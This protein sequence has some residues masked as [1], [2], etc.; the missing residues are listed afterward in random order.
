MY[1]SLSA[2]LET[3][4]ATT[5]ASDASPA[6]IVLARLQA[7]DAR[8]V[9]TEKDFDPET[10]ELRKASGTRTGAGADGAVLVLNET[11]ATAL[12]AWL[13]T[14]RDVSFRVSHVDTRK[15]SRKPPPPFI[16]SSLQQEASRKLG[17]SPAR[18]MA[19]AQGLYEKGHITYMRTDSYTL[20]SAAQQASR[21]MVS[22]L[23]GTEFL[24]SESST[25]KT[26]SAS[27]KNAQ[28]AHEAIRPAEVNGKFALPDALHLSGD[29]F[30]LYSLIL[31]RTLASVMAPSQAVTN[32]YT[33]TASAVV[34]VMNATKHSRGANKSNEAGGFEQATFK[35]SDTVTVF[36]GYLAAQ[37]MFVPG[38]GVKGTQPAAALL[39]VGQALRLSSRRSWEAAAGS[40]TSME[41]PVEEG[42]GA[43]ADA[44]T[45]ESTNEGESS[46]FVSGLKTARHHTRPP[47]RFTESSFI[48]EMESLGV[49][50][51]STYAAIFQVLKERGYIVVDRQTIIPTVRGMVV[52]AFLERHFPRF[53]DAR[54][55]AEMEQ[56]L[57]LIARNE[58]NPQDF[59]RRFYL[60]DNADQETPQK[61][62]LPTVQA[63]L[64]EGMVDQAT[65]RRL[66]VPFLADLGVL[67]LS[68][69]TVNFQAYVD[70]PVESVS[71]EGTPSSARGGAEGTGRSLSGR[72]WALPEALQSDMRQI[73]PEA[74]R[75]VM[76]TAPSAGQGVGMHPVSQL[77]MV[78]KVG[79]FGPYL[80]VGTSREDTTFCS[81]PAWME[82]GMLS[83]DDAVL[84]ASLPRD[85]GEHP[86][87][88]RTVQLI[89]KSG[90]LEVIVQGYSTHVE[91]PP[92]TCISDVTLD[93][94]LAALPDAT[95]ISS[96]VGD[97]L[98]GSSEGFPVYAAVGKYGPYVRR[99]N[100]AAS[101][102]DRDP[103]SVS[104]EE[105]LGLLRE[106]GRPFGSKRGKSYGKTKKGK[107]SVA[108][109]SLEGR[110]RK[111]RSGSTDAAAEGARKP[112][113]ETASSEVPKR[114]RPK[115]K[116]AESEAANQAAGEEGAPVPAKRG[117]R[118][119]TAEGDDSVVPPSGSEAGEKPAS[120]GRKKSQ[121]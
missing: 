17:L 106:S 29:D 51:P 109:P 80:Q 100:I 36:P 38:G 90:K 78:F 108:S 64:Q 22:N 40:S 44:S 30:T 11:I 54:F 87:L 114:G 48:Q 59:L 120:K 37:S 61:G 19:I 42:D 110:T 65:T 118:K 16:T 35:S 32:T 26:K 15:A 2:L 49:G 55:T 105:A 63:L 25:G 68:R 23:F 3:A 62:L 102:E 71:D 60:T 8:R 7:V 101:L 117:R 104:L 79:R 107:G 21:G 28:E 81:L 98:L 93:T 52:S 1:C 97:R 47:S 72:K 77:L 4:P 20:S 9:A 56:N 41:E 58:C 113:K 75:A 94:A 27:P 18:T 43:G 111:A 96:S 76:Q 85:L 119:A 115:S 91:L 103:A 57:D 13:T 50:R 84:Y 24:A 46:V 73:T 10:G 116:P 83:A 99:K 121:E 66:E 86:S 88:N 31:R 70:V 74:V 67:S 12:S 89:V 112:R 14:G 39:S 53:V 5:V 34:D 45:P 92:G 82:E 6:H 69:D 95:V 33:I